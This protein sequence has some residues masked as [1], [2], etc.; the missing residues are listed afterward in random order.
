MKIGFIIISLLIDMLS[1]SAQ[2]HQFAKDPQVEALYNKIL[3]LKIDYATVTDIQFVV[4]GTYKPAATNVE[5][6]TLPPFC[7]VAVTLQPVPGSDIKIE[8]WLPQDTWNG[9]LLG[10]G[11]G[12]GAGSIIYASLANGIRKGYA[13]ANTDMG[14]S[15]GGAN[16][17]IGKP[18]IWRDF[19]Y[20]ATH[21]MTV[22]S[23]AILLCYYGKAQHHAYFTGCSTGGQQALMEAQRF[24]NDYNG[25]IVGAPAN[26]RTHLHTGFLFNYLMTNDGGNPVFTKEELGFIARKIVAAYAVPTGGTS[27]DRFLT[28]PDFIHVNVEEL[29]KCRPNSKDTC[30]SDKQIEILKKI[31]AGPVNPETREQIYTSPPVGS[32]SVSGGLIYQQTAKGANDL[33]YPFKWVFGEQFE[34]KQFDF[35]RDLQ[36]LDSVLAPILNAND[37]NLSPYKK[38]GGKM[39]MYAGTADPLVPYQ[40]ALNYYERVIRQQKSLEQTQQFFR[41]YLIP[42]MGHC[43]GGPG[44]NGFTN[45]VLAELVNWV[46]KGKAPDQLEATMFNCAPANGN[47]CLKRPVF[48]Y[49]RFPKYKGGDV[50]LPGSFI[51]EVRQQNGT[52]QPADRYLK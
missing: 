23:K 22:V 39:M 16:G 28:N 21:L 15:H 17:A 35:N 41:F 11:N 46:E 29:F 24:P 2:P 12:G 3:Q 49:P 51:D 50:T 6:T 48:P 52:I 7:R 10:T 27:T 36:K 1:L 13:T 40:D 14:T 47:P 30:L 38:L 5:L 4:A 25:I 34:S 31:Y 43:G 20:R 19:G 18:E 45:D 32:E 33:F 9:R 37:P 44:L 8:L 42:G 26:N